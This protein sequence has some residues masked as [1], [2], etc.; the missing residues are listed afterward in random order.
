[1]HTHI[2]TTNYKIHFIQLLSSHLFN[3][4][5]NSSDYTISKGKMIREDWTEKDLEGSVKS[6]CASYIKPT[7]FV[8]IYGQ[9][10]HSMQHIV[11]YKNVDSKP[12]LFWDN[13]V[14]CHSDYDASSD[15]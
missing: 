6:Y 8:T 3:D 9:R 14:T 15:W 11:G 10:K 13:I 7:I 5:I 1:M 12:L 2:H 4:A